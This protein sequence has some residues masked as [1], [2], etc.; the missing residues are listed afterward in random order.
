MAATL[1]AGL[2][3]GLRRDDG[4]RFGC[5]Y[6]CGLCALCAKLFPPAPQA[7][8]VETGL[9]AYIPALRANSAARST[10]GWTRS[11]MA[12]AWAELAVPSITRFLMP[13]MIPARRKK[14]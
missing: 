11:D 2:G 14:L 10:N 6:L 5:W 8:P 12:L 4:G 7:E 9:L 1:F 3:P 13:C